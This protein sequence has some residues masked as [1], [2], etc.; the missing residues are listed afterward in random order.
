MIK[1]WTDTGPWNI[2]DD[3]RGTTSGTIGFNE[4]YLPTIQANAVT[5]EF[6]NLLQS[7][8]ILSN[9]FKIRTNQADINQVGQKY[10]YMAFAKHP[11]VTSGGVPVVAF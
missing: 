11:F 6:S 8:D 5:A 10:I 4:D 9:G 2:F 7:I 1:K 3:R